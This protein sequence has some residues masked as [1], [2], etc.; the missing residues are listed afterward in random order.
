[1]SGF[2]LEAPMYTLRLSMCDFVP[3][4]RIVQR[5]INK[6]IR[7]ISNGSV[8]MLEQAINKLGQPASLERKSYW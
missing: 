8:I 6:Y 3:Y 4:D 2:V 5:D 1:M 7:S